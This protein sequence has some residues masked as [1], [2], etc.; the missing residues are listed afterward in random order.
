MGQNFRTPCYTFT[1]VITE[2]SGKF[3]VLPNSF[4][5][6][7]SLSL[8]LFC[9]AAQV[10]NVKDYLPQACPHGDSMILDSEVQRCSQE[11]VSNQAKVQTN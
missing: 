1:I 6:S 9:A 3:Q 7:L 4:S 2:A 8:S 5:L 11:E 10:V